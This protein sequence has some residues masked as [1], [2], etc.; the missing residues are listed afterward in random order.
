MQFGSLVF[1]TPKKW[2]SVQIFA[3]S[4][5]LLEKRS[6]ESSLN[7]DEK[8]D[9]STYPPPPP[10]RTPAQKQGFNSRPYEVKPIFFIRPWKAGYWYLWGYR[11][12]SQK[13]D[14][15]EWGIRGDFLLEVFLTL[16][17]SPVIFQQ[18]YWKCLHFSF[19][20]H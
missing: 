3:D 20:A 18:S 6:P 17:L 15:N 10:Q 4:K 13:T 11:L 12:T 14:I 2:G 9:G 19:P 8:Y 16:I 5:R 1:A 7:T